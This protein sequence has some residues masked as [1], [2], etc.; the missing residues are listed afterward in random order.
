MSRFL[1]Q[2]Y[3]AHLYILPCGEFAIPGLQAS[4]RVWYHHV[5]VDFKQS[6]F[7]LCKEE[8]LALTADGGGWELP[9]LSV[10]EEHPPPPPPLCP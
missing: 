10:V 3:L 1:F 9:P 5:S 2:L 7:P 4:V 8:Q 6:E